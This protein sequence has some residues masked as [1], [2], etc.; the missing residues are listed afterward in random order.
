LSKEERELLSKDKVYA[1]P[2]IM[3]EAR[4]FEW[5][6]ISFGEEMTFLLVKS[7]KRLA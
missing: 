4:M 3:E 7:I 6:G 5:A 1:L 2:N